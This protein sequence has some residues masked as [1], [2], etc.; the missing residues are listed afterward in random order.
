MWMFVDN[1]AGA[2][3]IWLARHGGKRVRQYPLV[4][5]NMKIGEEIITSAQI[6][7]TM[8]HTTLTKLPIEEAGEEIIHLK[9]DIEGGSEHPVPSSLSQTVSST[10][11]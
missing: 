1:P 5:M 3:I 6:A 8:T 11:R 2:L 9:K 10:L 4:M 7:D